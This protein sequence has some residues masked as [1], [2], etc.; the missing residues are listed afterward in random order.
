MIISSTKRWLIGSS[1]LA[2]ISIILLATLVYFVFSEG[3][4][5]MAQQQLMA[6]QEVQTQSYVALEKLLSISAEQRTAM[7]TYV[8][9]EDETIEFLSNIERIAPEQGVEL[10]TGSLNVASSS[11][12]S[13]LKVQYSIK[14]ETTAVERMLAI[15]E[16]LP[17]A[18][19]LTSLDI[20]RGSTEGSGVTSQVELAVT[21][22][23]P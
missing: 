22:R 3:K 23:K 10:I 15:L 9:T 21:L 6:N 4:K 12:F 19:S 8:L 11:A 7:H 2:L 13:L 20:T 14:G 17:Y 16:T 1:L 5:L 18:S